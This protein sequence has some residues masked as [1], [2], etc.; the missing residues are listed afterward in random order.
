[1]FILEMNI[2]VF[3]LYCGLCL[4]R[5]LP[6][7]KMG[8]IRI[9]RTLGESTV[10]EIG[11]NEISRTLDRSTVLVIGINQISRTLD[12]STVLEIGKNENS[13]TVGRSTVLEIGKNEISR[14]LDRSTVLENEKN[15]NSR[16]QAH[17]TVLENEKNKISRTQ[18]HAILPSPTKLKGIFPVQPL[19]LLQKTEN[20]NFIHNCVQPNFPC[21]DETIQA[22]LCISMT[23]AKA[24]SSP[25]I[26]KELQILLST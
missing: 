23:P 5:V 20:T 3:I 18:A 25:L 24:P 4:G 7:M 19:T 12:R 9:S 16:T 1:M 17:S 15:Q 6:S 13:R 21:N 22:P 8:K 14:T 26:H 2:V 10:L 11:K